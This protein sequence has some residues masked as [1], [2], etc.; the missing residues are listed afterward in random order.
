MKR[1]IIII[2]LFK[3][4]LGL[5]QEN[6]DYTFLTYSQIGYDKLLPKIAMLQNIDPN[7]LNDNTTFILNRISDDK[8]MY[9]GKTENMGKKWGK[10]W[11][12][13]DFSDCQKTGQYYLSVIEGKKVIYQ[14]KKELPITIGEELLWNR[15]WYATALSHLH[16]RDSLSYKKEG[17][18]KD[19]GS[20]LQEVSSHVIMLNA[21]CDLIDL[22]KEELSQTQKKEIYRQLVVGSKYIALCQDIATSLGYKEGAV[23][24]E[25]RENFKVVTGNVAKT[26]MILARVSRI[27]KG[28]QPKIS[29][30]F[31]VRSI[32]AYEWISEFG[33][34]LH[35]DNTDNFAI[36]HGAPRGMKRPP[37]EW[38]TRDLVMM[39]WASLELYK[40]GETKYKG[41]A[42][43][44]ADKIMN[45]QVPKEKSE[46]GYYGHFYTFDSYDF[47]EK[48]N[49][50]CGAWNANYKAYN[51]GGH[52]PHYLVPMIEMIELWPD[53]PNINS[54]K[55]CV[56]SFAYN[57]FLPA[58]NANPFKILPA[59]YYKKEG[60]LNWSGWYHGHNKIFGYAAGL[61][62]EFYNIFRD[63]RFI[64][65]A[66]G[67]LQWIAG[68][69]SGFHQN[70]KDFSASMI[71]GIGNSSK[72]DWDAMKGTITNGFEADG[73]FKLSWPS[74]ETDLP[75]VFGDE[76]GI[77]HPAGWISG[78]VRLYF[79]SNK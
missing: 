55:Q 29:N 34:V 6:Y 77:H 15:T 74:K 48:A 61:A 21:L 54:W 69:H 24:H 11:W 60:L 3:S 53:D 49:I 16:I 39:M 35:W 31:K 46:G 18:W 71:V 76:G 37:M 73:Q 66:I 28:E 22:R 47:T 58:T 79:Y 59:G 9:S 20:T 51:Q 26:S 56:K 5:C 36:T 75:T 12:K 57:Y 62:M 38:M 32:K 78:L 63:N 27:L 65:I 2:L 64:D 1:F 13:V 43:Y 4:Y 17:G 41:K 45:R 70:N 14:S 50:H 67:N 40:C 33:P 23:I 25:A 8:K 7:Y 30:E 44:Y 10:Y 19:C 42:I 52:F 68:L 72:E